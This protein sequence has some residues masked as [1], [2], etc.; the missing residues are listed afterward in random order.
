MLKRSQWLESAR[1]LD[2]EFSYVREEEVFP[3]ILSGKPWLPQALW[4][5]WDEPYR[6]SYAEYVETQAKKGGIPFRRAGG[7]WQ[8]R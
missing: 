6:T 7:G 3:E 8:G 1:K 2:W 4:K 5:E